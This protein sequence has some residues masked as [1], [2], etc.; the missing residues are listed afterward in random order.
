MCVCVRVRVH[1]WE[2]KSTIDMYSDINILYCT[3]KQK[4]TNIRLSPNVLV[5]NSDLEACYRVSC[6]CVVSCELVLS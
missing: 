6:N 2:N 5:S 3:I 1:T 4:K